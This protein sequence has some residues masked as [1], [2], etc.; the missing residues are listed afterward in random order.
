MKKKTLKW[1]TLSA[2]VLM[3]ASWLSACQNGGQTAGEAN[4]EDTTAVQTDTVAETEPVEEVVEEPIVFETLKSNLEDKYA[5]VTFTVAYP[6]SG[7]NEAQI[8]SIREW[9]N[10]QLG[11]KYKGD[12]AD[13]QAVLDA[14]AK[15]KANY[16]HKEMRS[17]SDEFYFGEPTPGYEWITIEVKNKT[18]ESITMKYD[19]SGW[20]GDG[21]ADSKKATFLSDGTK[22]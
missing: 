12:L 14:N 7:S 4:A 10:K 3:A 19:L 5:K 8:A 11:G 20:M 13:G 17:M 9:I 6:V 2:V 18:E 21:Y 22:K 15:S 16:V 1:A